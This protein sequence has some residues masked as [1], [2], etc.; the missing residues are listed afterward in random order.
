MGIKI[1]RYISSLLSVKNLYIFFAIVFVAFVMSGYFMLSVASSTKDVSII[2]Q[3]FL[4]LAALIASIAAMI[5]FKAKFNQE[6]ARNLEEEIQTL[7]AASMFLAINTQR[8]EYYKKF[9]IHP[10]KDIDLLNKYKYLFEGLSSMIEN[11]GLLK[12]LGE[13]LISECIGAHDKL[14]FVQLLN[15]KMI[16]NPTLPPIS[17]TAGDID[18]IIAFMK[19]FKTRIDLVYEKQRK[20]FANIPLEDP[21]FTK[22]K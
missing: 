15:N 8:V 7:Y 10:Q 17:T 18:F 11:A 2:S 20:S 14:F 12:Y 6:V 19:R 16:C 21:H 1:A 13:S 22:F 3:V 5:S 4:G 9:I